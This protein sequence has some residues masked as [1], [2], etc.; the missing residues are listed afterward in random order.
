LMQILEP[1][2]ALHPAVGILFISFKVFV[3]LEL[4]RRTSDPE[5]IALLLKVQDTMTVFVQCASLFSPLSK[6][7]Q[8]TYFERVSGI[9]ADMPREIRDCANVCDSY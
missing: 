7:D 2:A 1:L 8:R 6:K 5:V 4:K 3:S 9:I